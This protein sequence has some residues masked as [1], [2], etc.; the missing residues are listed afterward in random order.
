MTQDDLTKFQERVKF[1]CDK[2][3]V[4]CAVV[5]LMPAD[6]NNTKL[7]VFGHPELVKHV[8]EG[9]NLRGEALAKS[10]A[11]AAAPTPAAN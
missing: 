6:G 1:N 9:L 2:F 5:V 11:Q 7:A 8:G 10:N 4:V 3:K